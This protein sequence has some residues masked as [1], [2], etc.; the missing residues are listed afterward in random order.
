[1]T[2]RELLDKVLAEGIEKLTEEERK[3]LTEYKDVDVEKLAN[4][5]AAK[6]RKEAEARLKEAEEAKAEAD[7][8]LAAL[9]EQ[10]DAASGKEKTELE[11]LQNKLEKLAKELDAERAERQKAAEENERLVRGHKLDSIFSRFTNNEQQKLAPG[12][13]PSDVR[14]LL[15]V[16]LAGLDLDDE[17]LVQ[18][19]LD[20]FRDRNK[21]LFV[22]PQSGG[23]GSGGGDK[24]GGGGG[25]TPK[26]VDGSALLAT[27]TTGS[28]ADAEAAV[29]AANDAVRSGATVG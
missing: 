27:A 24:G 18:Q 15:E 17:E 21:A 16:R 23:T 8:Q 6:A 28:L 3:Q 1:M 12:V 13:D 7:R 22:A 20:K 26:K 4:D 9:Q 2:M 14:A 10:I 11:K 5:R 29:K 19:H 25:R